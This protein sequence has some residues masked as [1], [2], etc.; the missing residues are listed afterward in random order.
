MKTNE[1][2]DKIAVNTANR[3]I[4][5]E[6]YTNNSLNFHCKFDTYQH[7]V[8]NKSWITKTTSG[9]FLLACFQSPILPSDTVEEN[10]LYYFQGNSTNEPSIIEENSISVLALLKTIEIANYQKIQL[11]TKTISEETSNEIEDFLNSL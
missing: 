8:P 2:I 10:V 9:L 7:F 6:K 3:K 1:M 5:W 4:E 11:E